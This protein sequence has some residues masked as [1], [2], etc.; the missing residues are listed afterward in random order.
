MRSN[1]LRPYGHNLPQPRRAREQTIARLLETARFFH[2]RLGEESP[3]P[4][5]AEIIDLRSP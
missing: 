1:R 4:L 2:L 5:L 3:L